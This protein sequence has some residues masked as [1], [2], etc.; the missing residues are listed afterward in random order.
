MPS[1]SS[2]IKVVTHFF[3]ARSEKLF[4]TWVLTTSGKYTV[5]VTFGQVLGDVDEDSGC[6]LQKSAHTDT[7]IGKI[8]LLV[9]VLDPQN[10]PVALPW[11][12][13]LGT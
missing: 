7:D 8:M 6:T 11:L 5:S 10:H 4:K 2:F 3:S 1:K 12:I 13:D 9:G